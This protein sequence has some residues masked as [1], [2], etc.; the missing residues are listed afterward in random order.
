MVSM[1][2]GSPI[3]KVSRVKKKQKQETYWRLKTTCLEPPAFS[4]G[5]TG[6]IVVVVAMVVAAIVHIVL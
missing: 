5:A 2:I 4:L 3:K 1:V 6:V